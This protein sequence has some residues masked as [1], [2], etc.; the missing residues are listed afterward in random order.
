MCDCNFLPHYFY[1][2][3]LC[4]ED[5]RLKLSLSYTCSWCVILAGPLVNVTAAYRGDL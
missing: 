5:H 3:Q 2:E 4:V 1:L